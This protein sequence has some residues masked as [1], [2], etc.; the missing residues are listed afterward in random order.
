MSGV[1]GF[2]VSRDQFNENFDFDNEHQQKR[3]AKYN[4]P[5]IP[6]G[7]IT[8]LCDVTSYASPLF[9]SPG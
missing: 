7:L 5:P 1:T 8:S 6:S 3:K 4:R 9:G 2:S